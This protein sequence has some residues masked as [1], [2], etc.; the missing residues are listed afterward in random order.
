M[1]NCIFG[2]Y[3]AQH[4]TTLNHLIYK[5]KTKKESVFFGPVMKISEDFYPLAAVG[6][7]STEESAPHIFFWPC[8]TRRGIIIIMHRI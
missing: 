2:S 8:Q 1:G 4:E 3:E 7:G 5:E 6:S